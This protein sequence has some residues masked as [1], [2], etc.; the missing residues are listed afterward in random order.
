MKAI[1]P[2]RIL[3]QGSIAYENPERARSE[4]DI[5]YEK[6]L[7]KDSHAVQVIMVVYPMG[8]H[9]AQELKVI[10]P[11]EKPLRRAQ[12]QPPCSVG[13]DGSIPYENPER[14][15]TEGNIPL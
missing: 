2:M 6:P 5:P 15:G 10:Y 14:A 7:T 11:Y 8:I 13:N 3:C 1:Y 12:I 4:G 9:N